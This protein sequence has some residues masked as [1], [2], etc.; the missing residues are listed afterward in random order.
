MKDLGERGRL[1]VARHW[2]F[3]VLPSQHIH[4][5]AY[6]TTLLYDAATQRSHSV[7]SSQPSVYKP[8]RQGK[9]RSHGKY[10][11]AGHFLPAVGHPLR[12][13][14]RLLSIESVDRYPGMLPNIC[15][16]IDRALLNI[17]LIFWCASVLETLCQ[18]H[19]VFD[20]LNTKPLRQTYINCQPATTFSSL[21]FQE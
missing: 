19:I 12:R 5:E 11:V 1:L 3:R 2:T 10:A 4:A 16:I 17:S 18:L 20:G 7:P 21:C 14:S 15:S 13:L 6:Q 8:A 9:H